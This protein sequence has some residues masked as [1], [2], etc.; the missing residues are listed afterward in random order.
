MGHPSAATDELVRLREVAQNPSVERAVEAVYELLEMEVAFISRITDSEQT[1]WVVR[2]DGESFGVHDGKSFHLDE[3]YCKRIL[4]GRLPNL[5]PDVAAEDRAA[6]LAIT[7]AAGIGAYVS[8]PVRFSDGELYGTLCAA[9]HEPQPSLGYRELQFLHVFARMIADALERESLQE[10]ARSLEL[11]AAAAQALIAAVQARDAYT[12]E[13]SRDVVEDAVTV[14]RRLGLDAD[15]VREVSHVAMLHDIG[16]IAV[17][18]AIL[19]KP[20]ALTSDEWEVMRGHTTSGEDLVRNTPGLEHLA[21]AI[22]A[23]HERWDGQGYPDGL[24]G[25]EIPIASRI[26]F[27]C[28]AYHAMTSDRPYRAAL[29]PE[30]A[31]AEIAGGA[32]SQFCP[33]SARAYLALLADK[34]N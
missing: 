11:R 27:V 30:V 14:A 6:S 32:G 13:H 18:D 24:A 21:P 31:R 33:H 9:S 17:P 20:G 22:R 1:L 4:S 12:A 5:I 15:G 19:G 29:S 10:T 3:T 34:P 26:T 2:G 16:K 28:D 8:V 23:E 7:E 25:E